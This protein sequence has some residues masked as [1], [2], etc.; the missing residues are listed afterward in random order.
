MAQKIFLRDINNIL[1]QHDRALTIVKPDAPRTIYFEW[2]R[3]TRF[4]TRRTTFIHL[5]QQSLQDWI[6]DGIKFLDW[7]N[8][9][10]HVA[11]S[12]PAMA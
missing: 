9:G 4:E 7:V 12:L 6:S 3:G 8:N 5:N 10:S 1:R 2:S 11:L